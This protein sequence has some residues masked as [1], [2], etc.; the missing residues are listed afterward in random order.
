MLKKDLKARNVF[1]G[2]AGEP[3]AWKL[4]CPVCAVRRVVVSLL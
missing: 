4:A 1:L 3:D 2:M